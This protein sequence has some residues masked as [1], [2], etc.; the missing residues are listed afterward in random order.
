MMKTVGDLTIAEMV[1]VL[2]YNRSLQKITPKLL[3]D[4]RRLIARLE[5]IND[6]P[7]TDDVAPKANRQA[8][9]AKKAG[10]KARGK[11][12]GKAAATRIVEF[13]TEKTGAAAK[14]SEIAATLNL[15]INKARTTLSRLAKDGKIE[16][17]QGVYWIDEKK[18]PNTPKPVDEPKI[19]KGKVNATKKSGKTAKQLLL[20]FLGQTNDLH[21]VAE[22][23]KSLPAL[24]PQY[25]YNL[26]NML[27]KEGVI[28]HENGKWGMKLPS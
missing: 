23:I 5:E 25:I 19:K 6:L 21:P 12:R 17:D 16:T 20:E 7:V 24:R 14:V 28:I 4:L 2:S 8:K 13:L 9:A 15:D 11:R 3:K 22:V 27:K 10:R 18:A 1:E 26:L